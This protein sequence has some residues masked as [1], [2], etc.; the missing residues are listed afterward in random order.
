MKSDFIAV[1]DHIKD[2]AIEK[3]ILGKFFEE[4]ISQ[5]TTIILVWHKEINEKFLRNYPSIRAIVRYGVGFDNIDLSFC[6][7]NKIVVANT[8]D[9]GVDEVADSALAMILYLTRKIGKL[10]NLAK[11]DSR[12]WI[13]K[14][15]NQNMRR[16]NKLNLGIIG[17]G[18]IGGSIAK[19]FLPF[20]RNIGFYDPYVPNGYEKVYGIN[21]FKS[22]SELLKESDIVSINTPLNEE[23]EGLV[24]EEFLNTMKKGSYLINL[25]RGPIIK[26]NDLIFKKLICNHLEGY[27]TDVWTNEPPLKNDKFYEYLI[28]QSNDL[29][30][31]VIINPHTA[32]YSSEASYECR[33]KACSTCL[34][35]IYDR[36]INTRVI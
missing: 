17:L 4:K 16:L 12:Y 26:N 33:S 15:I 35:I 25:S 27:G 31:R 30:G 34:D 8:P 24:N 36:I 2:F 13:G 3:E 20:S 7:K 22:L 11:N 32:Y 23:T 5:K 9:Y 29:I 28:G 14:D 1:T 19:K 10:E 6:K 21:R 18:R